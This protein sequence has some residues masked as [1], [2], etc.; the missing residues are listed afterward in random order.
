[1]R[2]KEWDGCFC[3]FREVKGK[4]Q[5]TPLKFG[6]VEILQ[7]EVSEFEFYPPKSLEV[8]AKFQGVKFKFWHLRVLWETVGVLSKKKFGCFGHLSFGVI[9]WSRHLFIFFIKKIRKNKIQL[10]VQ[11]FF[12]CY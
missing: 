11:K 6:G 1:M 8:F 12:E 9:V 4:L 7:F 10:H 2:R 5:I 3:C